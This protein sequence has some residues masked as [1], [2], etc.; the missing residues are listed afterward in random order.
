MAAT[1]AARNGRGRGR[2]HRPMSE[3]NVTPMVDVMLVLLVIFM[4]AAPLLTIGVEVDLPEAAAPELRG[5]DEPLV[6]SIDAQGV[7]FLEDTEVALEELG[8]RLAA[9]A[10]NNLEARVFVRGDQALAYGRVMAVMSAINAAGFGNVAMIS[11]TP[12]GEP[13]G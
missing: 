3:I 5:Q 1:A 12:K 9:V 6:V 4:I 10:E 2:K 7:I 13:G 11:V 8:P